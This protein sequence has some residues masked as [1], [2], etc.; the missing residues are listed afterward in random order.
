[1]TFFEHAMVGINGSLAAGLHRR[2]GWPIVAMAG[3]T[4]MLPDWDGLTILLGANCYAQAHRV[5]G[6]NLLVAGLSA[7]LVSGLAYRYHW[8]IRIQQWLGKHWHVFALEGED[9]CI[10][11]CTGGWRLWTVVGVL[12]AYSHLLADMVFSAGRD[13]QVW[14]VPLGWPFSHFALAYPLVL[15]GDIGVTLLFVAGMFAMFRWRIRTRSIAA[16]VLG[17]VIV[18]IAVRGCLLNSAAFRY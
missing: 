17:L 4:A 9:A 1:M 12:A 3:F 2:Y 11:V 16:S 7:I 8:P 5:W 14:G 13:K 10:P 6:H 15:W 18:Y